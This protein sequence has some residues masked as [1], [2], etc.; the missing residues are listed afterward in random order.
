MGT[1]A[2]EVLLHQVFVRWVPIKAKL[3]SLA[4]LAVEL[5]LPRLQ[6]ELQQAVVALAVRDI[7]FLAVP[8]W[9]A[10]SVTHAPVIPLHQVFVRWVPIKAKLVSLAVLAVVLDSPRLRLVLHR[11]AVAFA[12]QGITCLATP[13]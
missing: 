7:T 1:L 4:V 5:D 12:A 3:V 13:A 9:L 2:L 11:A 8:A 6:S 10:K